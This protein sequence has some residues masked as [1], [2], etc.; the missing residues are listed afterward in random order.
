MVKLCTLIRLLLLIDITFFA[1][2][3]AAMDLPMACTLSQF[4]SNLS[5][6]FSVRGKDE[7][8]RYGPFSKPCCSKDIT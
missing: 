5:Y 4:S 2:T 6:F 3:I 1:D 8:G 7:Y